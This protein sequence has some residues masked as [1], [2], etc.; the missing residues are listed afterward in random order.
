MSLNL[1]GGLVSF[2]ILISSGM[3][4]RADQIETNS[5]IREKGK[6][7][8][9]EKGSSIEV[10]TAKDGKPSLEISFNRRGD[11]WTGLSKWSFNKEG[12]LRA[13]GWFVFVE[14]ANRLWVFD[15]K[16]SLAV[17]ETDDKGNALV[18]E[19]DPEAA[20]VCPTRVK[21]ALPTKVRETVLAKA[22]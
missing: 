16:T 6:Y 2:L 13:D 5:F 18:K 22:N 8:F 9:D 11:G 10:I 12:I 17:L 3:A 14:S 19:C 21:E 15:G 4:G 20:V 1:R 7:T